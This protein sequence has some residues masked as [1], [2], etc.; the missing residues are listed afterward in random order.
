MQKPH[1]IHFSN[2][3]KDSVVHH[4]TGLWMASRTPIFLLLCQEISVDEWL[5]YSS[6]EDITK[7]LKPF[8]GLLSFELFY[9]TCL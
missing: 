5:H 7:D 2:L 1:L 9:A 8:A 3:P 4:K 6:I